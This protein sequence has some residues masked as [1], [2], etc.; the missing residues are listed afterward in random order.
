MRNRLQA[1]CAQLGLLESEFIADD[2]Y[3]PALDDSFH[4]LPLPC[5][6]VAWFAG[7]LI[8]S[9]TNGDINCGRGPG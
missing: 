5:Q 3:G 6:E 1:R 8:T 7:A 9:V 2:L 4:P